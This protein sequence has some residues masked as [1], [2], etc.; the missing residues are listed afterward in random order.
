MPLPSPWPDA[1]SVPPSQRR[2]SSSR[3]LLAGNIPWGAAKG[4]KDL[5]SPFWGQEHVGVGYP[6]GAWGPYFCPLVPEVLSPLL[7]PHRPPSPAQ[8]LA[9][10]RTR[11]L[12]LSL[13]LVKSPRSRAA[14][15]RRRARLISLSALIAAIA[16]CKGKVQAG[17][18]AGGGHP[19][20]PPTLQGEAVL[21]AWEKREI[22]GRARS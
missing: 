12:V 6:P 22:V 20:R 11:V 5:P 13:L 15:G 21:A 19:R 2:P 18:E 9:G 14:A 16:T 4:Q 7:V 8:G 1:T 10:D 3:L 17:E